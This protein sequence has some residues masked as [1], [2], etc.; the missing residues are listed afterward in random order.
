MTPAHMVTPASPTVADLIRRGAEAFERAGLAYGH[1][2]DNAVD[3]AAAL[4]FH[5]L[6][7]EHG[8]AAE[9]YGEHPAEPDVQRVLR[10][11]EQR[12]E[13]RVPAAYLMGRMWFAGLEFEL[14]ERVIVPRSPFA[15]LILARFQ[16]WVD[17]ARV[18]R[19]LDIGTGSGCIA[20][21]CA[22]AFPDATVDAVDI[23]PHALE[24]ARRNVAKHGVGDRVQ[25]LQG[26]VFAPVSGRRYDL[27]VANPP[28]VSDDE[29]QALPQEYRHEPDLALRAGSD[30][31]DVVRRILAG[32]DEHLAPQGVLFVEVGNSD[33]R[34]QEAFPRLPFVWLEFEQGGGGLFMLRGKH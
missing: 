24:V 15:E 2:T 13:Q 5:V 32:A 23:S 25:L 28:Y 27:I 6:G 19:I 12:I 17:P 9:V 16:P 33:E 11:F 31:L 8:R 30:G 29:M 21:A 14:D 18:R 22:K 7:L 3:E 20:I 4:V 10:V 1:G 26:D 34:V